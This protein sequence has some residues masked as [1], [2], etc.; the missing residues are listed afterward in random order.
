MNS[1]NKVE[2]SEG[3]I[4]WEP[5]HIG[6][7]AIIGPDV[8]IGCLAHVGRNVSIGEGVRVQGGAYL[9]DGTQ[10]EDG[11]FIGPNATILNDRY[12]PSRDSSKWEFVT[13][14]EGSVIGG[15]S[16]ILPGV[17]IGRLAVVA[18]GAIVTKNIPEGEV[19]SGNPAKF[20]MTRKQYEEARD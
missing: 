16:T 4:A 13:L 11:V 1:G 18:A 12:P 7:G 15:G 20:H 8:S 19:W 6:T 14:K 5:C 9:A 10:V 17:I 2:L 3:S